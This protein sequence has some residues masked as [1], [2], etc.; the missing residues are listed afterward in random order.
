[1]PDVSP[2]LHFSTAALA[3]TFCGCSPFFWL[4]SRKDSYLLT[5]AEQY[6]ASLNWA[7]AMPGRAAAAT[8]NRLF[9]G[10]FMIS[11]IARTIEQWLD[12]ARSGPQSGRAVTHH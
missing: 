11:S 10:A 9:R 3:A 4:W 8:T 6:L 2:A 12:A 5:S 1:M 7:N